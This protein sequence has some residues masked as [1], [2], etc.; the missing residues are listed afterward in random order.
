M[1][2]LGL[3]EPAAAVHVQRGALVRVLAVAQ[4]VLAGVGGAEEVGERR[5]VRVAVKEP[6]GDGHVVGRGVLEGLR[7]QP[8]ALVQ[9]EAAVGDGLEDLAVVGGVDDDGHR[10]VVLGGG[11]DH[12]GAADVDL[13]HTLVG[14]GAGGHGLPERVEVDDDQV[15]RLDAEPGQLL[16]VV[17]QA[18]V[19]QDA[20][21]HLR[22][23]GLDPAVEALGE[24]RQLL[25]LGDRHPGRSD[26]RGR[27][28]GGD[29]LDARR[30]QALRQLLQTGLVVDADQRAADGPLRAF[31][32]G[33]EIRTFRPSMR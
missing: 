4:D 9:R 20:G 3:R 23:Q 6:R 16:A 18:E 26:L 10:R 32:G 33:H 5:V 17:L 21:V 14:G 24:A 11:A 31:G 19:G 8:L 7:R 28:S 30:V 25:D 13:L 15:E 29:Q 22:V 12:R 1:Q 27:R 2:L